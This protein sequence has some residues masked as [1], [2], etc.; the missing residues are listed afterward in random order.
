MSFDPAAVKRLVLAGVA[1]VILTLIVNAGYGLADWQ[2]RGAPPLAVLGEMQAGAPYLVL[3]LFLAAVGA[4][5]GARLAAD[6]GR[7]WAGLVVGAGLALAAIAVGWVQGRLDFWLP[8]N[9]VMAVVG[10]WLGGWLAGRT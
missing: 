9:A 8:P 2:W 4:I 3:G 7:R 6:T 1:A 5:V 10:G